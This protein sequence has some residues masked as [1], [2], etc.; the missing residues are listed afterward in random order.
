MLKT[1]LKKPVKKV[2]TRIFNYDTLKVWQVMSQL[3]RIIISFIYVRNRPD[4]STV[5]RKL[6]T[7][8]EV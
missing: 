2:L 7:I 3:K 5:N 4:V 8:S 6:T 1:S